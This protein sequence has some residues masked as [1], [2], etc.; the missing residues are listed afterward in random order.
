[1]RIETSPKSLDTRLSVEAAR[2][3]ISSKSALV[4]LILDEHLPR[5]VDADDD[6]PPDFPAGEKVTM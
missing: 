5:L 6:L 4:C 3:G 2:R 1:M